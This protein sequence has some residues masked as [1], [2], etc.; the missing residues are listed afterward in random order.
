MPYYL[1]H[2]N[3][4]CALG[5]NVED[6]AAALFATTRREQSPLT[7]TER[8]S[9]GRSFRLGHVTAELPAVGSN[10]SRYSCRNNRLLLHCLQPIENDVHDLVRKLGAERVGIVLGTS[11]SGID[12]SETATDARLAT[13][14]LPADFSFLKQQL[15]GGTDFLA[16]V[17][18]T[19]GPTCTV[20]TA[21]SSS[22]NALASAARLLDLEVVDAVIV[23]GADTLCGFTV[24]GFAALEAMSRDLANPMSRNRDGINI[25]E[26]GVLA[27]L[28]RE[29]GPVALLGVG[30]SSDAHHISAPEPEGRG[31]ERAM[32]AALQQGGIAPEEVGY[33]NLHGTATPQNDRA[34]SH[35]V[36]RVVGHKV[37]CSSSK[38]M[39]GHTLGAAGILE[40]ALCHVLMNPDTNPDG[41]G[42]A[43]L[44]DGS[45]DP[46]LAPI[47]LADGSAVQRPAIVLSN[48]FAF[49]GN[50][51]SVLLASA[52]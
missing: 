41:R 43:N 7:P 24:Q 5:S 51:A 30:T 45:A 23:G 29:P 33:V 1:H 36:A 10:L 50:N 47:R 44:W 16:E 14:A 39:T 18:G 32:R 26:A 40:V 2:L 35:A 42:I 38:P 34:E 11:T 15:F 28:S 20:S 46:D 4:A 19:R 49:G 21:C 13:G 48:S 12:E 3:L 22:A 37:P 9:P 52:T 25:G 17:L 6:V 27:V 31:A 8:Y